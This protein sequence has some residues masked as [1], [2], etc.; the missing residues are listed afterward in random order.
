VIGM[1]KAKIERINELSRKSKK[2]ELTQNEKEEQ[3][4]L[5]R[6]YIEAFKA[7]LKNTLESIK[8]DE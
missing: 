6:E 2:M 5:R 1:E 4:A 7:S 3:Q 8:Y